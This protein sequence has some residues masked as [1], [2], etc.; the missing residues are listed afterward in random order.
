[1]TRSKRAHAT[2]TAK[3]PLPGNAAAAAFRQRLGSS[4]RESP[5]RR[6]TAI[7]RR[8]RAG[9]PALKASDHLQR[10][11]GKGRDLCLEPSLIHRVLVH[12]RKQRHPPHLTGS[13]IGPQKGGGAPVIL[14][15]KVEVRPLHL[16]TAP[17][18]L[19]LR[20]PN[21][22]MASPP[23]A[24]LQ[25]MTFQT[26]ITGMFLWTV[27]VTMLRGEDEQDSVGRLESMHGN[28]VP[29]DA[30]RTAVPGKEPNLLL[31][32]TPF[33][34][35][36]ATTDDRLR[37]ILPTLTAKVWRH[38]CLFQNSTPVCRRKIIIAFWERC[39]QGGEALHSSMT[40]VTGF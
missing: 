22:S 9:A 15:N 27:S 13:F 19:L 37:I 39:W 38:I 29:K 17:E 35:P 28:I 8:A 4:A 40:P 36:R 31:R 16:Q 20:L 6:A 3:T 12:L 32:R 30:S 14:L 2:R 7:T 1:M 23:G 26:C 25:A 10:G 33:C 5:T 24:V 34:L 18:N 21:F 11:T